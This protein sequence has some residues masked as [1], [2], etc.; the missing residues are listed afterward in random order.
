VA[1]PARAQLGGDAIDADRLADHLFSGTRR[2]SSSKKFSRKMR[3]LRDC[4]ALAPS[5]G[6]TATRRLPSG[7]RSTFL[8]ELAV[9]ASTFSDHSRGLSG[10]KESPCTV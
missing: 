5:A 8:L 2:R 10:T 7:A 3:W 6:M 9:F 4:C 1:H